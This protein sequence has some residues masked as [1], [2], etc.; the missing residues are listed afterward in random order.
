MKVGIF[1]SSIVG[2]Q[3]APAKAQVMTNFAEGVKKH[4]DIAIKYTNIQQQ[5]ENINA[6]LVLG[7]TLEPGHRQQ[8]ILNLE[9]R[10]IPIIYCDSDIFVYG[11]AN[12]ECL[13]YSVNGVYANKGDYFLNLPRDTSKI[14]K[15]LDFHNL[16]VKPWRSN[17]EHILIL[18]QRTVGWNMLGLNGIDWLIDIVQRVRAVTDR[19]IIIR[20][21]P[22]DRGHYKKTVAMLKPFFNQNVSV[23]SKGDIRHDL[24]NAWCSVG[25]CSTPNCVS[26]IEGIPVYLDSPDASWAKNIAFTDLKQIDKP[27]LPDRT[28]WLHD[29]AHIHYLTEEILDGV[30]WER[31]KTAY[32]SL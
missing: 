13:R 21:H 8:I 1:Y 23:S 19:P 30:Y 25:Y 14:Q 7:Y 11:K 20:L 26:A 29:I 5:I 15:I 12:T 16:T 17:G 2:W 24:A 22:G 31:F 28:Q 9:K 6:G 27:P 3:T 4:G 10:E 32:K 18:G